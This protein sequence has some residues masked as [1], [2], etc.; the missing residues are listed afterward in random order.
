[1]DTQLNIKNGLI[2]GINLATNMAI[3]ELNIPSA[4]LSNS[5]TIA[6]Y[7]QSINWVIKKFAP[8]VPFGWQDNV[9]AGD[10]SGHKWLHK[11]AN[12]P[13]LVK[14]HIENETN[15]LKQF[16]VFDAPFRPDFIAFDKWERDE[17]DQTLKGAGL[18][19]G[20]LYNTTDWN[21]YMT[22][23]NGISE[24]LQNL[25]VMLWQIPGGH[26]QVNK[27]SDAREDHAATAADYF[28]GDNNLDL[29]LDNVK[30]YIATSTLDPKSYDVT[31]ANVTDYLAC[32]KTDAD[33]WHRNRLHDPLMKHV[34]AILWGGGSTTGIIGINPSLDDG[35]WLNSHF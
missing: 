12:N 21:N 24:N 25:P 3:D 26:L 11:A 29:N 7:A 1:L 22:F 31:S 6:D 15:F 35:G 27:D 32:P 20:Y 34:F 5:T 2:G 30:K 13:A 28:L 17:F 18:N 16:H 9:W 23:V 33:C 8:H 14:E 4:F 19:N 10:E